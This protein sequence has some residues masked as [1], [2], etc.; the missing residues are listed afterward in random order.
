MR[1]RPPS[2]IS[3]YLQYAYYGGTLVADRPV[4][5]GVYDTDLEQRAVFGEVSPST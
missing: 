2:H 3:S 4:V 1:T 5:E